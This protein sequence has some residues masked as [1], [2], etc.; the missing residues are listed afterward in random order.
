[1]NC[2][3]KL[4]TGGL[5]SICS[6]GKRVFLKSRELSWLSESSHSAALC[7]N[8]RT[9][10]PFLTMW[11]SA[12]SPSGS[13]LQSS[14]N[15]PFYEEPSKFSFKPFCKCVNGLEGNLDVK[16]GGMRI[17]FKTVIKCFEDY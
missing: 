2:Q 3:L 13:A 4:V 1:M 9:H 14:L 5:V 17:N 7:V 11:F 8:S 10:L 15:T 16:M 6:K 12:E